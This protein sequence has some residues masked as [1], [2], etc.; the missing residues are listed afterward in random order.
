MEK[1]IQILTDS[2]TGIFILLILCTC[3]FLLW[4]AFASPVSQ[5]VTPTPTPSPLSHSVYPRSWLTDL[6]LSKDFTVLEATHS[7]ILNLDIPE[8]QYGLIAVYNGPSK[9][10]KELI[11]IQLAEKSWTMSTSATA[12]DSYTLSMIKLDKKYIY[13]GLIS[14]APSTEEAGKTKLV[15]SLSRTILD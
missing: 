8:E 3:V 2:R 7:S 13:K 15:F 4:T 10:A 5:R 6:Y 12:G 14:V 9:D 11:S 1:P